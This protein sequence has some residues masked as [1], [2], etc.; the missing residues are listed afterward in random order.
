VIF[1]LFKRIFKEHSGAHLWM[2]LVVVV[3]LSV[4]ADL[5]PLLSSGGKIDW[6]LLRDGAHV[7][8]PW[9][10]ELPL[11]WR[12][13]VGI[14]LAFIFVFLWSVWKA[15][16]VPWTIIGD[17]ADSLEGADRYFAIG[18]IP[19]RE[20]F[21]PDPLLYL[22]T[23]IQQQYQPRQPAAQAAAGAGIAATHPAEALIASFRHERVLL[24]SNDVDF[25]AL[26]ASYLDQHYAR[27]FSAI[28]DRFGITLAYL[29]K[30]EVHEVLL[31]LTPEQRSRIAGPVSLWASGPLKYL[32]W[33]MV[34]PL[35]FAVTY[36][37]TAIKAIVQF[38]KR[39]NSLVVEKV[40]DGADK[41]ARI[42]FVEKIEAAIFKAQ[43][44]DATG[45]PELFERCK[46][47]KYLCP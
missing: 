46:F 7:W 42:A 24:F 26:Q 13:L 18:T 14:Y 8:T 40:P 38:S 36:S 47:S 37:G 23:I 25:R 31:K 45:S 33:N 16:I 20:W 43:T 6:R 41:D 2:P 35:P 19:L 17:L 22:A 34:R 10:N 12:E 32:P 9:L 4:A 11:R 1:T 29:R 15:S 21:E 5:L 28:H 39:S 27:S 30:N 3:L 44:P